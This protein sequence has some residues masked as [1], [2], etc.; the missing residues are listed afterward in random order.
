[1]IVI[2]MGM[3]KSGTSL[4]SKTLHHSG[5]NMAPRCLGNYAK[6]TYEDPRIQ[7]LLTKMVGVDKLRSLWLPTSIDVS[8]KIINAIKKYIASRSGDWG[9]KQPYMTL[10]YHIWK[11]Y[12][13][14]HIAIGIKRSQEGLIQHYTKRGKSWAQ[15]PNRDK[16]LRVQNVHNIIMESHGIPIIKFED[17]IKKGPIVLEKIIGRKLKDVRDGKKH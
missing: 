1:M 13:P 3:S 2:V 6:S 17:F 11:K 14:K 4:V 8:D 10:C 16:I 12:L 15:Q 9:C 7:K 5:I